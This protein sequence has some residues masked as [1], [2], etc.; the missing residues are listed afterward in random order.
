MRNSNEI[1]QELAG[2]IE[3]LKTVSESERKAVADNVRALTEELRAVRAK[4]QAELAL[5]MNKPE[6]KE[7]K[8]YS[9][10]KAIRQM[11]QGGRL[12]GFEAEMDQEARKEMELSGRSIEGLG[13]PSIV[14]RAIAG[15]QNATD[16]TNGPEF[17]T[18]TEGGYFD[19][20]RAN[21]L[22]AKLGVEYLDNLQGNIHFV[23]GGAFAG[24]WV[25]EGAAATAQKATYSSIPMTPHRLQILGGYTYDL[26]KQ[27]SYA[28]ENIIWNNLR[29]SHAAALDSALFNGTGANGQPKGILNTTGVGT[30]AISKVPTYAEVV[31]MESTIAQANGI[32]GPMAFVTNGT[33]NGTL[34]TTP[35]VAGQAIFLEEG[36]MVNG[37]PV[38]VSSSIAAN[39]LILGDFKNVKVGQWGGLDLIV[40]PYSSK[41]KGI[42]EV[43]TIA[44]HDVAVIYPEAFCVGTLATS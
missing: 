18:T 44:Y 3:E 11:A 8:R 19:A 32:T 7:A 17:K 36:G 10:A 27:S 33:V 35:K 28:V 22:G 37:C 26:L 34:K 40:D 13:V 15:A 39:K 30:Q 4:E 42:V 14:L 20:L 25:A 16:S 9:I 43:T 29:D 24:A 2:K 31:A 38:N 6:V 12:D 21:L 23:K 1:S 5:A 41:A